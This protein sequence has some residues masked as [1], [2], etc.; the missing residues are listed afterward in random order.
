MCHINVFLLHRQWGQKVT[1]IDNWYHAV[2]MQECLV[3]LQMWLV[4][5]PIKLH[6]MWETSLCI[7]V[8]SCRFTVKYMKIIAFAF[9]SGHLKLILYFA[10]LLLRTSLPSLPCLSSTS[11]TSLSWTKTMPAIRSVWKY[12]HLSTTSY[13]RWVVQKNDIFS[14]S[15]VLSLLC[16]LLNRGHSSFEVK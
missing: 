8:I 2:T 4:Q 1:H 13:C 5:L 14:C 11:T 12:R 3:V 6:C 16:L 15:V 7:F 9:F 10:R